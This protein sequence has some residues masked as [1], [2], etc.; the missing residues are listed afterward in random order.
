MKRFLSFFLLLFVAYAVKAQNNVAFTLTQAPC[1]NNGIV[2]ASF[3]GLTTPINVTWYVGMQPAIV[4]TTNTTSDVLNNY[5][6]DGIWLVAIGANNVTATG[7]FSAPPFTIAV[8][9]VPATCPALGT[10]TAT[11]TGGASP[12]SYQWIDLGSSTLVSTSNPASLPENGYK[13][14]VTDANGCTFS[15]DSIYMYSNPAFN[16]NVSSTT[17]SCTNG[18]ATVGSITG[19]GTA[20]YSYLWSNG[21]TTSSINNLI[22]GNYTVTVTDANGCH[23][24]GYA[25]ISQNPVIQPNVTT[26]PATCIQTNG[27]M[28]AFGSGGTSPYTYSWSNGGTGQQ[29]NNV[30]SGYYSVT[31]TDANGCTGTSYSYVGVTSPIT[32]TQSATSSSCTAAT[33]S[34]S[35]TI[36]G[37]V[38]PYTVT[39]NTSPAQ[40]GTSATGLAPGNYSFH[41]TDANGCVR[42]GTVNVPP[43]N[44]ITPTFALTNPSCT[45]ANGSISVSPSGGAAPYTYSWSNSATTS[46]VNGLTS[47]SY[48]VTI[49]DNVGCAV[50][51]TN[52]LT[53][54]TPISIGFNTTQASCMYASDGATTAIPTGGTAPYT[55]SWSNSGNTATINNLAT[56]NYWVH[57]SDANGCV[58][59]QMNFVPYNPAGTSCYCTITGTVY[60]DANAN[61]TQDAGE[62]GIP[63][64]MIHCSNFGYAYTNGSGVY[65]FKVPTGNYTISEN[66][67]AYYPLA[68]CQSNSIPQNI[69]ASSGCVQ[70]VD[71]A[72]VI[73]PIHDMHISTWD[74]N[75]PIPG[76]MYNR[77]T[78]ISNDGTVTEPN[79]VGSLE[80][81]NQIGTPSFL[82]SNVFTGTGNS[83]SLN[84]LSLA[85]GATKTAYSDFSIP[86]NIPLST[87]LVF[88]DSVAYT[89]PISNWLNDYSPWNN[90]NYFTSLTVGS[91]DPNFKEVLPQGTGNN[92]LITPS[93]SIL[94][95]MVHFQNTGS[96]Y[97]QKVV[98]LDTLDADLDWST[99]RPVYQSHPCVVTMDENGVAKFT[100][101]NINLPTQG[102]NEMGSNGMLTYTI[103]TK[104][105]LALGTTF[106]N[107][108]AIY[109]DYN[110]PVITNTTL[111][112][113]GAP[114]GI[115][116]T[117]G[118][119]NGSFSIYPNPT[120][121]MFYA[122]L[123]GTGNAT[124]NMKVTD[125]SGK[126]VMVRDLKLQTGMQNIPVDVA[127]LSPGLYF[128]TV[129]HNGSSQT[130]K[131]V[132][133]K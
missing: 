68:G 65:S 132:I 69:T 84:S 4:H 23:V 121:K 16:I 40:T 34:A 100:F 18:T 31:V 87:S 61:C 110:E 9:T 102:M 46:V 28:V 89:A 126:V 54:T 95:Y 119:G 80:T 50:T 81:D 105:N 131:L 19:G 36:G 123:D 70:T 7:S 129:N 10:A 63:N 104:K 39:W 109:F 128:V 43:V 122:Q 116:N 49:T 47:G 98:V 51:K 120:A 115:N 124:A 66:V 127:T 94:E 60:D 74:Y 14:I 112:T 12:Y 13:L 97:A 5:S 37:G 8:A 27:S 76:N 90:V 64:I 59:D 55:Y 1:N 29:Q 73:N 107:N 45:A 33:G 111:N 130:Q 11:I 52:T 103:H 24:P 72:N 17:A 42:T 86:T 88:K 48:T 108:A 26:T 53:S 71:F 6:G 35:L 82:P 91:F 15:N 21:A 79:I 117:P 99:L 113:L 133:M 44:V 85:P 75:Q 114:A 67:L 106:T 25:F 20:P 92:G 96:Y 57:V 101:N 2:T 118:A 41:I 62:Q 30:T 22:K 125:I 78:I 38:A 56:G 32:V 93:D 77:V 58:Q 83:F 3:T